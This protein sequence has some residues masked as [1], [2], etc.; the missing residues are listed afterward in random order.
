MACSIAWAMVSPA[1]PEP[2][3]FT[4]PLVSLSDR[5]DS[6][7]TR[8]A[9]ATSREA[10]EQSRARVLSGPNERAKPSGR[11][12]SGIVSPLVSRFAATGTTRERP[13]TPTCSPKRRAASR[14]WLSARAASAVSRSSFGASSRMAVTLARF[15]H[16]AV[17]TGSSRNW[18]AYL[19]RYFF[20]VLASRSSRRS[21][22]FASRHESRSGCT[23]G[24]DSSAVSCS[25]VVRHSVC[26]GSSA[27]TPRTTSSAFKAASMRGSIAAISASRWASSVQRLPAMTAG[28]P[29]A[30]IRSRTSVRRA[31]S[32]AS[33]ET[34]ALGESIRS[35]ASRR[36]PSTRAT[37]ER[38]RP[39][40]S[41]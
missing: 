1:R 15:R 41:S 24:A 39:A 16:T 20:R 30:A 8:F 6:A 9:S 40:A 2:A 31:S 17:S 28:E 12:T 33:G 18:R 3:P 32:A 29:A 25:V 23:S 11:S 37:V 7:R 21:R 13:A 4:L 35:I 38:S 26:R 10:R 22:R 34:V 19:A 27:S 5:F 14:A 36:W